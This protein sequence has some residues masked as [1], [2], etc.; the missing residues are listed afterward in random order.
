MEGGTSIGG[1]PVMSAAGGSRPRTTSKVQNIVTS[2]LSLLGNKGSDF[3][4][5]GSGSNLASDGGDI[6]I[7]NHIQNL[8]VN[9]NF[10]QKGPG[11][12]PP[13]QL[14]NFQQQ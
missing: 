4:Y 3:G 6:N 12:Q 7:N 1:R 14:K 9:I 13:P 2:S 11:A 8:N 5:R 10:S